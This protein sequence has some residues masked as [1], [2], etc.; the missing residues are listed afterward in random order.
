MS[1]TRAFPGSKEE[2]KKR[3]SFYFVS[4]YRPFTIHTTRKSLFRILCW[5]CFEILKNDST[6]RIFPNFPCSLS[7]SIPSFQTLI[8]LPDSFIFSFPLPFSCYLP[9]HCFVSRAFLISFIEMQRGGAFAKS[10]IVWINGE[11]YRFINLHGRE[12]SPDQE[13]G[14]SMEGERHCTFG[15]CWPY[16][17]PSWSWPTTQ[18]FRL[19]R[20][21]LSLYLFWVVGP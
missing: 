8:V 14:N 3:R 11:S 18:F 16:G 4:N 7:I 10:H 13:G 17:T 19:G 1:S 9:R 20:E 6:V 5:K 2:K 12:A 21:Q 15:A